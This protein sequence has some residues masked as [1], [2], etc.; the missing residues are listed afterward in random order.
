MR[1]ADDLN[2]SIYSIEQRPE[3]GGETIAVV[4]FLDIGLSR[5]QQMF[6]DLNR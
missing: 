1:G 5:S 2:A 4:F 6:A 3:L